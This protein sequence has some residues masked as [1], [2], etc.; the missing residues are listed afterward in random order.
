MI[1]LPIVCFDHPFYNLGVRHTHSSHHAWPPVPVSH[2]R[3]TLGT[4][5]TETFRWT[6]NE[7]QHR[8]PD[9]DQCP[10][11]V[12]PPYA[13][14]SLPEA[15]SVSNAASSM[16]HA[17]ATH[18]CNHGTS[19]STQG[20]ATLVLK[21]MYTSDSSKS[22]CKPVDVSVRCSGR[23]LPITRKAVPGLSSPAFVSTVR[24]S[25]A[26]GQYSIRME[27]P[28]FSADAES[29]EDQ[30]P[31]TVSMRVEMLSVVS[32]AQPILKLFLTN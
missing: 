9:P 16:A 5:D 7:L 1:T 30:L 14:L 22:A 27:N 8:L 13:L 32:L 15:N 24:N 26:T 6:T 29:D 25:Y 3:A 31:R 4:W 2:P 12:H 21:I 28:K 18:T 11:L 20:Q 17:E 23:Y 10:K 19:N